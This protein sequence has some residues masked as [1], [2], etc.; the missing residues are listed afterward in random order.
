MEFISL[1]AFVLLVIAWVALPSSR[2]IE[3]VVPEAKAA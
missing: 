3:M 1:G 2:K